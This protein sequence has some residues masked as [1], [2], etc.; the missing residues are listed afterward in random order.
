[1][2]AL[3]PLRLI[4]ASFPFI[5]CL[6]VS[7]FY[8]CMYT[9]GAR[10]LGARARSP[11]HKQKGHGCKHVDISQAAMISKF[12]GLALP[13]GFVLF[14]TPPFLLPFSL[15]CIVLGISCFVTFV[16]I[17]RVWRPL[18][19][20]LHL[21]F[22]PCSKDVGIYFLALCICIVHDVCI[23]IPTRSFRCDCHSLCHLRQSDA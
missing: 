17:S 8:L 12:R 7:C 9:H 3:Y 16:L 20:L 5:A 15:R 2:F 13:F 1:M 19:T 21:N 22:G 10:T 18:F 14:K 4:Y 11:R 23:Y 6:L